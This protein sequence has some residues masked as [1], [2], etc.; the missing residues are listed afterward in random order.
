M[1]KTIIIKGQQQKA[2]V[3]TIL[4]NLPERPIH[5]VVIREH[6]KNRSANQNSL[7]WK[8]LTILS[9][10]LG[11][12]KDELHF[13]YRRKYLTRIFIRDD[14]G[15]ADMAESLTFILDSGYADCAEDIRD[16]VI[17]LTSTT[18]CNTAQMTEYM[19]DIERAAAD[20]GIGLPHP[21]DI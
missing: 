7:Y 20:L 11:H 6:K 13:I 3:A 16:Q 4:G 17:R 12:T 18:Q 5:E 8:W 19:T 2:L 21:E 9:D 10:E 15:Y 1:K 14:K